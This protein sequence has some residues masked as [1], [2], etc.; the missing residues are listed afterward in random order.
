MNKS[1]IFSLFLMTSL[2]VGTS[3]NM[4][5]F[6]SAMAEGKDRDDKR[7]H[8]NNDNKYRQ[9]AYE[10]DPYENSYEQSY[11]YDTQQYYGPQP[12]SYDQPRYDYG[13]SSYS[14]YS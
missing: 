5:M 14:D 2:L 1:V 3:L 8:Y 12:P 13:Q 11:A 9:S 7:D 6:S 4:N 10:P